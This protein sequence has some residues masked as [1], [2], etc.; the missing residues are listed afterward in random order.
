MTSD[1][2]HLPP[3]GILGG[4]F[5]PVHHGHLRLAV[6][7]REAL[8]LAE[9]RLL[10][11]AR[12]NLRDAACASGAQRLAMLRAAL[13]EGLVLDAREIER[14]GVSYTVDTLSAVRAGEPLR[15]LCFILGADAWN[16]LPRWHR[17]EEL[18]DYAHLV[19]ASRPGAELRRH[20]SLAAAWTASPA[21]L[22]V[23]PAGRVIA[24]AIPLLPI[25]STDI[26]ARVASGRS[27]AG[28]VPPGVAE[29]IARERLYRPYS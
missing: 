26:R 29:F 11:A 23:R 24:C 4:T 28:L 13:V 9:V 18:L 3:V 5:D 15:P 1:A 8:G 7:V 25:S 14:G 22:Q 17:W 6:E 21:D 20:P 27:L 19:V 12:T 10:P 16:A 2:S